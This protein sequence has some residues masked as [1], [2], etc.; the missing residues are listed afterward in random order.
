MKKITVLILLWI[1]ALPAFPGSPQKDNGTIPAFPLEPNDL[2]LESPAQPG[3][4]F[5]KAGRR[6]ALLGDEG[7]SFEAWAYPLKLVRDFTFSFFVGSSTRAIKGRDIAHS[8]AVSPESAVLTFSYQSFTVKA[9]YITPINEAGSV[10]LL[11]VFSNE[12]LTIVCGF[13]PELQPMWPAGI[14]GQYAYWNDELKAYLISEPT[15]NNHALVGSPAASGISYTPAH[16]LSDSPNEFKIEIKDPDP[17]RQRFIPVILA[18]GKG[19]RDDVKKLYQKLQANPEMIYRENVAHF[20]ELRN[21]TLRIQTPDNKINLAFEWAKAAFDQLIVDNPDLGLGMAAG[22]GASGSGGRPGFGWFFGGDTYINSFSMSAYGALETVKEMLA[23]TQ[24]WQRDDGK[25][26]HELSQAADYIDWWEDYPYGYIHGDTTPYYIAAMYDYLRFSGDMDFIKASWN[27]LHK[28]YEWCLNTD[29]NQDGLMDNRAAGLGALEY[30][31]L[32]GIETDIYLGAVWVRAA[33]AMPVLAKAAGQT[34][35]VRKMTSLSDKAHKAFREKF[36]N[37]EQKFYAY[38]FNEKNEH[39]QEISPW[40]AVGLMWGLGEP[41]KSRASLARLSSAELSTDWGIR[42]ISKK[43][44]YFQPL[45]Y[46]Y[47]AVWPFLTSWSTAALYQHHLPLNAYPL[48]QATCR[49]TF[50]HALGSI[51]E[52]FSGD[53]FTWPQEAVPHQGFSSAGVTLPAIRGLA[54]LNGDALQKTIHFSPQFPADWDHVEV[55]NFRTGSAV[56]DFT[57]K[58]KS[59]NMHI[60][61]EA[62][63]AEGYTILVSPALGPLAQIEQVTVNGQTREFDTI[64][65]PQTV[66]PQT[67][68]HVEK[69]LDIEIRFVPG[70]EII[71]PVPNTPIGFPDQGLKIISMEKQNSHLILEVEGLAGMEYFLETSG[72]EQITEIQGGKLVPGGLKFHI[73]SGPPLSFQRHRILLSSKSI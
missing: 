67:E 47:G 41:D 9:V 20:Q 13:I 72:N 58:R 21:S 19:S 68:I 61:I 38:A 65:G 56:F 11:Q 43:S 6:F 39:V 64:T 53:L 29:K 33:Y 60:H 12:P 15:Q 16:M 4:P 14:G 31:E 25:L 22:L 57:Y 30:G 17:Y 1:T 63:D 71:P 32:T 10:I 55:E 66:Q 2:T 48:L 62:S 18:G 73:P 46:N 42:S 37:P 54:G 50:D 7:G 40:N 3:S 35:Y 23:F 45:N 5:V 49:H 51:T 52:V 36:W 70:F 28:A 26:A 34:Q 27:S 59:G 8:F 24:K 44:R 69:E